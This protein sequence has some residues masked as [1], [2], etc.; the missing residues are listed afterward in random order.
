MER[1]LGF[2]ETRFLLEI[3]RVREQR[4]SDE[5]EFAGAMGVTR[6]T[7]DAAEMRRFGA[8][9]GELRAIALGRGPLIAEHVRGRRFAIRSQQID[10]PQSEEGALAQTHLGGRGRFVGHPLEKHRMR[11]SGA[12]RFGFSG[13]RVPYLQPVCRTARPSR[14]ST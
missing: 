11:K 1:V 5:V 7:N 8:F 6:R 12:V 4:R 10:E 9:A 14:A 2:L 13:H 3:Q